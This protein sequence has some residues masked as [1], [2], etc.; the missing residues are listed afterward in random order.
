[1]TLD[2]PLN[3]V[4]ALGKALRGRVL[5]RTWARAGGVTARVGFTPYYVGSRVG[6]KVNR[7]KDDIAEYAARGRKFAPP[8]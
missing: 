2:N 6:S 3:P 5:N 1:M 7:E 4:V 8:F